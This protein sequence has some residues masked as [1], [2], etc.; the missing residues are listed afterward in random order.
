MRK[1]RL[2]SLLFAFLM[3]CTSIP[4]IRI[5]Y[6]EDVSTQK[7][8][9]DTVIGIGL[10]QTDL[11][12]NFLSDMK[13]TRGEM[14]KIVANMFLTGDA[15]L[16][17][18][19]EMFYSDN[20]NENINLEN[21]SNEGQQF[22][23]V[24]LNSDYYEAVSTAYEY[25]FMNGYTDG[26]F[27]TDDSLTF[28]QTVKIV[29]AML[30]YKVKAEAYGGFP[31]G[32]IRMAN[33]LKLLA[34]LDSTNG[35]ITNAQL[36]VILN[37]SLNVKMLDIVSIG[38]NVEYSN[39]TTETFL[40][41]FL[42]M[43]KITGIVT[44][45]GY[46]NR[47]GKQVENRNFMIIGDIR[48]SM[49]E[50]VEYARDFLGRTVNAY[51]TDDFYTLIYAA[52]DN[53]DKIKTITAEEFVSYSSGVITYKSGEN[54]KKLNFRTNAYMI[55]N[56]SGKSSYDA[57]D[58]EFDNGTISVVTTYGSSV[59]DTV[60]IEAYESVYIDYI[61]YDEKV[62]Y[63][64]NN[65]SSELSSEEFD[66][67]KGENHQ[68]KIQTADGENYA[69]EKIVPFSVVS[70]ARGEHSTTLLLSQ[71]KITGF[72]IFEISLNDGKYII[73][74]DTQSYT[75]SRKYID[76]NGEEKIEV[77]NVYTL[78]TDIFGDVVYMENDSGSK[79]NYITAIL[80]DILVKD[81]LDSKTSI[82]MIDTSGAVKIYDFSPKI[83]LLDSNDNKIKNISIIHNLLQNYNNI[84][85]LRL[86][87]E[88]LVDYIELPI[89]QKVLGNPDDRLTL[90]PLTKDRDF[91]DDGAGYGW[92]YKN[93]QGFAGQAV[94]D[95]STKVFVRP[96]EPIETDYNG[97]N[98]YQEALSL[99]YTQL[100]DEKNYTVATVSEKF[101]SDKRY[102]VSCYTT[103]ADSPHAEFIVYQST[104]AKTLSISN[105][106]AAIFNRRYQGI[107]DN[108]N[109]CEYISCYVGTE[110]KK[111][112]ISD[113]CT[114]V[115]IVQ[116]A[117]VDSGITLEKGDIFRYSLDADGM[118]KQL[119]ILFDENET[120]PQGGQGNLPKTTGCWVPS[121]TS[122]YT[123]PY[124]AYGGNNGKYSFRDKAN[125]WSEMGRGDMRVA[126]YYPV[127][128][129]D[130]NKICLTT[131]PL[132][133]TGAI[134]KYDISG[135]T[136]VTDKYVVSNVTYVT[137]NANGVTVTKGP[138]SN[139]K[140]YEITQNDCNR[141]FMMSRVGEIKN[142]IVYTNYSK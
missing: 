107:D 131:Q 45:N 98:E 90:I 86:N 87:S 117:G 40:E 8:A 104:S 58:F 91:E 47:V 61:D 44:D 128:I 125:A 37:N 52:P 80:I 51:V 139:I 55:Y 85:R 54:T 66:L 13:L 20:K 82:K 53:L 88:G 15:E 124:S 108:G 21:E 24:D 140:T 77:G 114:S 84:L 92:Y 113:E 30:G 100:S 67:G 142:M 36:A 116:N 78:Y 76:N 133:H 23:D 22:S 115:E 46:S 31:N 65:N 119:Q 9:I 42:G 122:G 32:Y 26:S 18:W 97:T 118:V 50:E 135:S 43:K 109:K 79:G 121:D 130:T 83:S 59:S 17:K 49:H 25:G 56:G 134:Y 132:G 27:G 105:T 34:G 99:Y 39:T 111:L 137:I 106:T 1:N 72:K 71:E 4:F 95:S 6:A 41:R 94:T 68:I 14:A 73:S 2:F 70:I 81:G 74:N 120:N 75:I 11:E 3:I 57:S 19:K 103:K 89:T 28:E 33:E 62:I 63:S 138:C 93:T 141:V 29:I 16:I 112:P 10:M 35:E 38:E 129:R 136:F 126:L 102:I 110:E 96:M 7:I 48:V 101:Q 64:K 127:Y 5:V 60:V 123:N 12:G 69:F